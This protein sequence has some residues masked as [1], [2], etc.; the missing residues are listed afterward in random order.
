VAGLT[1]AFFDTSVLIAGSID[2]GGSSQHALLLMD[3]VADGRIERPM[4]A[5]HCCLE[6]YS[7]TTRLPEEY[8][9][10]P[11]IAL[12]LLREEIFPRFSVHDLPSERREEFLV[13]TVGEGAM[14]GRIYDAHIAEIARLAGARLVATENRRHFIPLLRHGIRVLVSAELSNEIGLTS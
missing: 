14:G 3:A 2:F 8:R 5:W 12:R 9:L 11:E 13:S 1:G 6:F 10:E 4:T 7:V